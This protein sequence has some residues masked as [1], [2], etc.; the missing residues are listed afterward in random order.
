MGAEVRALV[1]GLQ[2][3]SE[4]DEVRDDVREQRG[5]NQPEFRRPVLQFT[6]RSATETPRIPM[7]ASTPHAKR[8]AIAPRL[9]AHLNYRR[10]RA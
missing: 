8:A 3:G 2:V 10:M 6:A 4:R 5:P 9:P 1:S 7:L